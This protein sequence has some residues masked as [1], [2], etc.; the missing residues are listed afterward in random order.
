[1]PTMRF[2]LSLSSERY[3]AWYAGSAKAVQVRSEDGR[4]LRFPAA[5]LRPFVTHEGIHGYFEIE[6]DE[7]FKL[8]R[9]RRL[10]DG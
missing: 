1:M 7:H 9:L 2:K 5:E 4:T 3:L 10:S 8:V 6:F